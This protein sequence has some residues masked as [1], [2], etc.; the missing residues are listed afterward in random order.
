MGIKI[1]VFESIS[2]DKTELCLV[3]RFLEKEGIE[4]EE[5]YNGGITSRLRLDAELPFKVFKK[6]YKKNADLIGNV[7][8]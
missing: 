8:L 3:R 6:L 2:G 7:I 1:T 4:Y 5:K